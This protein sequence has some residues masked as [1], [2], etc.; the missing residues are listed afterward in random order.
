MKQIQLIEKYAD[1]FNDTKKEPLII[2]QGSRRSGKTYQTLIDLGLTFNLNKNKTIQIS[3]KDPS[4][5]NQDFLKIL[6]IFGNT[7]IMTNI[8]AEHL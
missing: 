4:N 2:L 5:E 7:S 8:A 3:A 6:T 1:F